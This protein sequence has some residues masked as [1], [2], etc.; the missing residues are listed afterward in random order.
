M[1]A[2][3]LL[4]WA[5]WLYFLA[6][7][8]LP[9]AGVPVVGPALGLAAWVLLAPWS[10]LLGMAL[11]HRLLP[12]S[13]AGTYRMFADRGSVSWA[14]KEWAPSVYLAVF[15]P[16][17]FLSLGFQRIALWAFQ[18]RLGPGAALTSRTVVRE[19]HHLRLGRASL[20]GEYAHLVCSYRPR[21]GILIVGVV[22]IGEEVL[23]GAHSVIGPG[24][25]IGRGSTLE[26]A[27]RVGPGSEIGEHARIEAGTAIY[28]GVRIGR[29][30]RIGK[31]CLVPSGCVIEDGAQIPDGTVLKPGA[32]WP[33]SRRSA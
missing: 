17:F 24:A 1:I 23:V 19:P 22:D 15:Q 21:P 25:R 31:G 2:L 6:W 18:A 8:A 29:D 32:T 16:V 11:L 26:L 7:V 33:G 9:L 28:S 20:V 27:V 3:E 10:S 12:R 30:V 14:L 13:E 5:G 4:W